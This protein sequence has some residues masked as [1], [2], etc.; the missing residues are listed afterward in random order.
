MIY[1][2]KI[3][4]NHYKAIVHGPQLIEVM[5]NEEK[6]QKLKQG[7]EIEFINRESEE[8]YTAKVVYVEH[9]KNFEEV[10]KRFDI[11]L[12]GVMS[13]EMQK[14]VGVL[15]IFLGCIKKVDDVYRY[16]KIE[17]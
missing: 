17:M 11:S 12:V 14:G 7:D 3:E 9:F 6:N 1:K 15:A 4:D 16:L 10:Y 8:S 2:M 13:G 5:P